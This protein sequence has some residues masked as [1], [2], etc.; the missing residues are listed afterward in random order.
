MYLL[1]LRTNK[2]SGLTFIIYSS[3]HNKNYLY[4]LKMSNKFPNNFLIHSKLRNFPWLGFLKDLLYQ[5]GC[6]VPSNN[7][8]ALLP[9]LPGSDPWA[10]FLIETVQPP[11]RTWFIFTSASTNLSKSTFATSLCQCFGVRPG[12]EDVKRQA[13]KKMFHNPTR[14]RPQNVGMEMIWLGCRALYW[15]VKPPNLLGSARKVS[16]LLSR[17]HL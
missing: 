3:E 17:L 15:Q 2:F 1:L 14:A 10:M 8:R 12:C 11:V 13:G 9:M 7:K 16:T 5:I 4:P 6:F